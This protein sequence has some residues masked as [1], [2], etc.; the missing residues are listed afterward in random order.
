MVDYFVVL[1]DKVTRYRILPI[2]VECS[3]SFALFTVGK[4]IPQSLNDFPNFIFPSRNLISEFG[5]AQSVV[6][7]T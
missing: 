6:C 7:S 3:F 1:E 2:K 5:G 4:E